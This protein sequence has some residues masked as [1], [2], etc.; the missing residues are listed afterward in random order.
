MK[1]FT[2]K[3]K[4]KSRFLDSRTNKISIATHSFSK[5]YSSTI[6]LLRFLSHEGKKNASITVPCDRVP[7]LDP[8]APVARP[9][10]AKVN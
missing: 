3:K 8:C 2:F 7:L 10:R 5:L 1:E 4:K 6:F 9:A